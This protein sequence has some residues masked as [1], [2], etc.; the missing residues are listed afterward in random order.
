MA[1]VEMWGVCLGFELICL[2]FFA[3]TQEV[4]THVKTA[5]HAIK[6]KIIYNI[7]FLHF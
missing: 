5:D 2:G 3:S 6:E 4:S 1:D 7:L